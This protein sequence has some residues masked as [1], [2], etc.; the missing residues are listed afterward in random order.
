MPPVTDIPFFLALSAAKCWHAAT[1][2]EEQARLREH[3]EHG[4]ERLRYFA[5]GCA[6][7]FLH[8]LRL[9]EAEYCRVLGKTEEAMARY[10]EAIELS[11]EHRFLHIEALALQLAAELRLETGKS[12]VGALYLR[13]AREAHARWGA[14]SVVAHLGAKYSAVLKVF[15]HV[16]AVER[17]NTT[18]ATT[19]TTGASAG[20]SFDVNTAVRAAQALSSELDPA[21]VVGRLMELV[22]ENAG[23][24][25]GALVL[26]EGGELSVAARLS[27]EGARIETGL[28]E[29]LGQSHDVPT[30]VVHYAARTGEP[31]VTGDARSEARFAGDPYLASRAVLSLLALPLTH[32][33]HLVGVLYLEHCEVPSAFPPAR[34]E[35][36]S[37]LASQAAIAV[38]NAMLYRDLEAKIKERTAE[39]QLAKE[40][41]DRANRAKSDFLSSMSHELRT[42]LNG[43]LGY[44]QILSRAAELSPKSREGV[45]TI[46]KSGEH[47]LSLLEDLLDL[48]K[49]EAGKM[50]LAPKSFDLRAFLGTV[51]DLCRVR[52][53]QKDLAFTC[54]VRGGAVSAVYGDEK[55][56]TQV[57][58][59]LLSNAIKF[60]ERGSVTLVVDELKRGPN[61]R[62]ALRFR[63]EDTG[64]GIAPEHLSCIFEPFEQVGD[65][66]AKSAGTGLGLAITKRIVDQMGGTI[67]VE[68]ELGRGSVFTVTLAFA[69]APASVSADKALGW[70]TI[71][72]YRGE[73]RTILVVDDNPQNRALVSDLLVP[74]GFEVV[75]AEDGEAGLRLAMERK[76]ALVLMDLAMP[77]MDGHEATR[78]LRQM[79]ELG[80]VVIL[81]SSANVS[82]AERQDGARVGWNGSLHK[83]VQASELFEKIQHFLGVE[84]V[85][86]GENRSAPE[87]RE[88]G[89][90]VPPSAEELA[91]LSRLVTSGRVQ[92]MMA[93]AARMEKNDPRLGPWLRQLRGLVRTYQLRKLQELI[94]GNAAGPCPQERL[95]DH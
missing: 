26:D 62:M 38:E 33:G 61:E 39:L 17:T 67:E 35:L 40:A 84:W 22:L 47:L 80:D 9:V 66:R 31:V 48:A 29:P 72:G 86:A 28:S 16:S 11:R 19:T 74:V 89:P 81:V 95:T 10:D 43:I 58:L 45:Q 70:D 20:A 3:I 93:E 69:E 63:V 64:P 13:E 4:L 51:A 77:G 56:L 90:V 78:R 14:T 37:V 60:T 15:T 73:R 42:P 54:E 82:G 49:I 87:E 36:L 76:P 1:G 52:A 25:R 85:H 46:K 55:R 2:A 30:T 88:S 50:D 92:Q 12:H 5:E 41:A 7:N 91:L 53:D 21:R 71:T 75:E 83:P 79:P 57:L 34:V 68:S 18:A 44:A 23:A 6:A 59:N 65:K 94:D 8:K 27:V 32:R 24:Q